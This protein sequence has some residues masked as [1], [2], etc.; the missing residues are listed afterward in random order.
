MWRTRY[1]SKVDILSSPVYLL[2]KKFFFP[3]SLP[4]KINPPNRNLNPAHP[5]IPRSERTLAC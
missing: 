5:G 2:P 4:E 1:F 3:P